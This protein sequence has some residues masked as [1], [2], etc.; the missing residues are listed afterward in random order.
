MGGE[1]VGD[2]SSQLNNKG[3]NSNV[4]LFLQY[5]KIF[6]DTFPL[7]LSIGMTYEQYWEQ[8]CMLTKYY[9]KSYQLKEERELKKKNHELWLQGA[10][11]Y[12]VLCDVAP[13]FQAF[14]SKGTTTKKYMDK[15]FPITSEEL[16]ERQ[17]EE[18]QERMAKAKEQFMNSIKKK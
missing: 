2:S 8:D 14:A 18:R 15:P 10:Y 1:L 17:D 13:I 5:T 3:D 4:A 9:L 6:E 7:Y 11:I 16:E 12:Q